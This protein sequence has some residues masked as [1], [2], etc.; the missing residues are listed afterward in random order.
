MAMEVYVESIG[1]LV[2]GYDKSLN[3]GGD[4]IGKTEVL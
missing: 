3:V 4:Y 2:T 1:N